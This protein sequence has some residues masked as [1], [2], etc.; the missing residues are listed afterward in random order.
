LSGQDRRQ[1]IGQVLN[2][3]RTTRTNAEFLRHLARAVTEG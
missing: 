1:A 3:L 2:Q